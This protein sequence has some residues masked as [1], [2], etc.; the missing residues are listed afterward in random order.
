MKT[1]ALL[2]PFG[3]GGSTRECGYDLPL[4]IGHLEGLASDEEDTITAVRRGRKATR[5]EKVQDAI[6]LLN[7]ASDMGSE[8]Q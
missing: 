1:Q 4:L 3:A 2:K 8:D 5:L 7:Q 6:E